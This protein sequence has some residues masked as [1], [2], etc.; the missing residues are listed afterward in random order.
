MLGFYTSTLYARWW[1]I[2]DI[3]GVVIGRINDLAPQIAALVRDNN[4]NPKKCDKN[5]VKEEEDNED[6][7]AVI[8]DKDSNRSTAS[9]NDDYIDANDVRLN[10]VRWLNLAHALTVGELYE[11]KP[12]AFSSLEKLVDYGLLTDREY[13]YMVNTTRS[14]YVAPFEWFLDLVQELKDKGQCGISEAT[15]IIF[16]QNITRIRG[17]LADLYMYRNVPV[18]LS[19]RQL[20]NFTVRVYMMVIAAA[21]GFANLR[22]SDRQGT[23]LVDPSIMWFLLSF[24]FE[25]FLFVG[26]LSIADVSLR[27]PP[28]LQ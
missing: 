16:S 19:Y 18:P 1:K 28:S 27:I 7:T 9:K 5:E 21:G 4:N 6:D 17:S 2:R 10:L 20:V 15:L 13:D 12:N 25:Y 22:V 11:K 14:R 23:V 26:W 3:E 24:V 8:V